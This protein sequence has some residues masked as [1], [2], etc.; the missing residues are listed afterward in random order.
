MTPE[1]LEELNAFPIHGFG[2]P[3]AEATE[4]LAYIDQLRAEN[5]RLRAEL[6]EIR[7][8]DGNSA[9]MQDRARAALEFKPT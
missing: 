5:E 3:C 6:T 1:R 2:L 8:H 7:D 9:M 4:A